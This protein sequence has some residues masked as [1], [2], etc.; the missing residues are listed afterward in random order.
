M[1]KDIF[2]LLKADEINY[3][4][5]NKSYKK[6][7]FDN[8]TPLYPKEKLGLESDDATEKDLSTRIIELVAPIGKGQRALL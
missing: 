4:K 7:N 1:V 2:A 3:N 8:L 6:A 5:V